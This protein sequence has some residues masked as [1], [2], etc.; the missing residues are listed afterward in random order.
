MASL[1]KKIGLASMGAVLAV[2]SLG[3][4][5]AHAQLKELVDRNIVLSIDRADVTVSGISSG[6][7][8]AHQVHMA[9]SDQLTGVGIVAGP[10]FRCAEYMRGVPLYAWATTDLVAVNLCTGYYKKMQSEYGIPAAPFAGSEIKLSRLQ[11]MAEDAFKRGKIAPKSGLCG[12]RAYLI[13]GATDDTVPAT[14]SGATAALYEWLLSNCGDGKPAGDRLVSRTIAGMPHTM[15]VDLPPTPGK[16]QAGAPYIAD[17]DFKGPEE[18]L[19]HLHPARAQAPQANRPASPDNLVRFDQHQVIGAME[20]KGL[21]HQFGYVYVP[22]ACKQGQSCPLHIA[23]HGCHQNENQIN[24]G[25]Y[26]TS[27]KW[28]FAADAGYNDYAERAGIVVLYPQA[29][30]T[31]LT[32]GNPN[33]CWDWWGYNG[34][35]FWEKDARQI[36]NIWK[37]ATSLSK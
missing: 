24:E 5:P 34:V 28:L 6:A 30:E 9:L 20:P 2:L 25:A 31:S 18:M 35:G 7:A 32:G 14:V 10:P 4:S 1:L 11:E 27:K 26:D 19:R 15:P 33:G 36:K 37:V 3:A 29:L 21:M 17:C 8:M 16:C 13:A 22:E 12:D 23:L